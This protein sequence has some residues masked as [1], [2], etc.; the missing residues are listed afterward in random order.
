MPRIATTSTTWPTGPLL[1]WRRSPTIKVGRILSLIV[2]VGTI[3]L[4]EAIGSMYRASDAR[5]SSAR[6]DAGR[7]LGPDHV[8]AIRAGDH[9][10]WTAVLDIEERGVTDVPPAGV[11]L[12]EHVGDLVDLVILQG[13]PCPAAPHPSRPWPL[14]LAGTT[15]FQARALNPLADAL[16]LGDDG[17]RSL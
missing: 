1:A 2:R 16:R 10:D 7:A 3:P 5:E 11:E 8:L 4:A 9:P 13:E 12:V 14:A 17:R 6:L 15:S